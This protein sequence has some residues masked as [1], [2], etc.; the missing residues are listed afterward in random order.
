VASTASCESYKRPE[1]SSMTASVSHS[2]LDH[3]VLIVTWGKSFLEI[4]T[5]Q[6]FT[7]YCLI[8]LGL[9]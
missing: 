7:N 4:E 2:D 9:L 5:V 8:A 1:V 6:A 3:T